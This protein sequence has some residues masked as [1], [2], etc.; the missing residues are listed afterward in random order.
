MRY[1]PCRGQSQTSCIPQRAS[2]HRSGSSCCTTRC[3]PSSETGQCQSKGDRA[4][5]AIE[6][7]L[8]APRECV[9]G[10]DVPAPT[11]GPEAI[12]RL[13]GAVDHLQQHRGQGTAFLRGGSGEA[14]GEGGSLIEVAPFEDALNWAEDFVPRDGHFVGHIAEYGRLDV[15]AL[16]TVGSLPTR[17][18]LGS[19]VRVRSEVCV[20]WRWVGIIRHGMPWLPVPFPSR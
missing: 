20:R 9:N 19:R 17:F 15:P 12:R 18:H 4:C 1:G 11:P 6:A 13:V 5:R 10:V 3:Q 7:R 14:C 2:R 8:D 16:T